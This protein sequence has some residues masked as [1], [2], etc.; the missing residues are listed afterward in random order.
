M[1]HTDDARRPVARE[2][3]RE[4]RDGRPP[5]KAYTAPRLVEYGSIAELT[6]TGAATGADFFGLFGG[7]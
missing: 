4:E 6:Q 7:W 3:P 2:D 1:T 5:R